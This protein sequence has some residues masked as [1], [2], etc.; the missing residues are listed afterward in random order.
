[1]YTRFLEYNVMDI[2]VEEMREAMDI[3]YVVGK[4]L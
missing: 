3:D 4:K 2:G 1:L